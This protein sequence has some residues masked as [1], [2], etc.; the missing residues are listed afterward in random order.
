MGLIKKAI[1]FFYLAALWY[2]GISGHEPVETIAVS[3]LAFT[4][5]LTMLSQ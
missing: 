1:G 2:A 3:W 4:F 5:F